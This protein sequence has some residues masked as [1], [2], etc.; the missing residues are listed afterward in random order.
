MIIYNYKCWRTISDANI[1]ITPLYTPPV[2]Q[3]F[4]NLIKYTVILCKMCI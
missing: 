1:K 4:E 2:V 3:K